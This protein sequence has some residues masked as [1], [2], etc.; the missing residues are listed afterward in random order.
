[1]TKENIPGILICSRAILGVAI[2]LISALNVPFYAVLSI[3]LLTIGL[4]TDIFDGIIARRL[5]IS[6]PRLRR[7]DSSVDQFFFCSVGAA[8]YLQCK[9]FFGSHATSLISLGALEAA[10]Y[11]V[12]YMKFRKEVATHSIG[13]KIWTLF[14]FA[15]IIQVTLQCSSSALFWIFFWLGVFSRIEI[16]AILIVLKHWTNDVP[17]IYHAVKLRRNQVIKRYKI[18]NG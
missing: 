10:I 11:V 16:I 9:E 2:L 6:T 13:A 7:L 4:L 3:C 12:S 18:F 5:N 8:T 17:S 14:L 15:T 1:M